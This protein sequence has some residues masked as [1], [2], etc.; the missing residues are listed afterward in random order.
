MPE[1]GA[2]PEG[3]AG[4]DDVYDKPQPRSARR[5]LPT[6]RIGGAVL[7]DG[8]QMAKHDKPLRR[9]WQ[10]QFQ[11]VLPQTPQVTGN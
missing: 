5:R 2:Q 3:D 6:Y 7:L 11:L 10:L 4:E 9:L 8:K 1:P